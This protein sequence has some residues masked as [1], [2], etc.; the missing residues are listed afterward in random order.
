MSGRIRISSAPSTSQLGIWPTSDSTKRSTS[1]PKTDG[2]SGCLPCPTCNYK[3]TLPSHQITHHHCLPHQTKHPLGCYL[4]FPTHI[5]HRTA[6]YHSLASTD[7]GHLTDSLLLI[8]AI[9]PTATTTPCSSAD[10]A[11]SAAVPLS[12]TAATPPSFSATSP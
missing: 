1:I 5:G 6:L 2:F 10:A 3:P 8:N 11:P 4:D 9:H 7:Q 12:P